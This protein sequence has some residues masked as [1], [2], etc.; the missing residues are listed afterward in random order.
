MWMYLAAGLSAMLTMRSSIA[1]R[2]LCLVMFCGFG[3]VFVLPF[4]IGYVT[5]RVAQGV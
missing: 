1:A 2:G 5:E 3:I 4:F